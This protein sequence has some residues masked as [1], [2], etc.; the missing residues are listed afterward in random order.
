VC[1]A[2]HV[3]DRDP[4]RLGEDIE[5][6]PVWGI[7]S[8]TRK[9][10]ELAILERA[11][12]QGEGEKKSEKE[13]QHFVEKILLPAINRQSPENAHDMSFSLEY[14]LHN[15][16]SSHHN[17]V[18]AE[19]VLSAFKDCEKETFKIHPKGTGVVCINPNGIRPHVFVTEYL[20]ELYPPYRWCERQ[21]VIEQAQRNFEL[22][23]ALPDFYNI[24]L[25]RPKQDINGY[26]EIFFNII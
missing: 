14:I 21:D 8:Y 1:T 16:C 7:D 11:F 23:P 22:K 17:K 9:M 19:A 5:E 25:E 18:F 20:G 4:L 15:S 10:V 3:L 13:I 26:G 6:V 12:T 2:L 24:L